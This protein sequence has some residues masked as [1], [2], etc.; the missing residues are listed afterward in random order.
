M[1]HTYV[2]QPLISVVMPVYNAGEFLVESVQSILN[3][4]YQKFEFIIVDDASTDHSWAILKKFA[5][6]DKRITLLRNDINLGVSL[7]VKKAIAAAK[8]TYLARMD[9]DDVSYPARLEK[10]LAY[11]QNHTKTVVVGTQCD[12]I[13]KDGRIIG[14][15]RFPM[16][17]KAIYEY[18][19]SFIPLQQ[20]SL[21]IACRRLPKNFDYYV[22]GLNT[23]EEVDL[24]FKLFRYGN[25]ENLSETL[26][27]YRLHGKN[28][29]L[30]DV[31]KTFL[32]T[33]LSRMKAIVV[34]AYR[35]SVRGLL[36]TLTETVIVL[37]LPKKLTLWLYANL[38]HIFIK[39]TPISSPKVALA[40]RS[41][42]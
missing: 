39:D 42:V 19:F 3:Q 30:L 15:K 6:K 22:D 5:K 9:A 26:L 23:A 12:V 32:L 36:M 11:L 37:L 14:A 25:V 33:L 8:G 34:Y 31:K 2:H 28:T 21:M 27:C 1:K 13:D 29:S 41:A 10:Q 20:P 4:T 40:N 16:H 7:T 24:I 35:P 38:K 18:I 17:H